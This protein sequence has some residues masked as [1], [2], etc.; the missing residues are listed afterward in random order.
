MAL[1]H[2]PDCGVE[3]SD[4]T[5]ACS[6]CGC[7]PAVLTQPQT[8]GS[9]CARPPAKSVSTSFIL[10]MCLIVA[11]FVLITV[12]GIVAA[13]VVPIILDKSAKTKVAEAVRE[14]ENFE[15][16]FSFAAQGSDDP[17][18]IEPEDIGYHSGESDSWSYTIWRGGT[19]VAAAKYSI[20][21]ARA[22]AELRSS[23]DEETG[24]FERVADE[25]LIR[26]LP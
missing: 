24:E 13:V 12:G 22:G 21:N 3:I 20:G 16:A 19:I 18:A 6:N 7:P 26:L 25:K 17:S 9:K 4:C 14:I 23:Y 15:A 1:I 8:G 5:T 11:P 10:I 2:C